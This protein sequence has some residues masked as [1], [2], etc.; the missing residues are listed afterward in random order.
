MD[1]K[2]LIS[3]VIDL[4]KNLDTMHDKKLL[5][6]TLSKM[7]RVMEL[8]GR[9]C[10]HLKYRKAVDNAESE[11]TKYARGQGA[12]AHDLS[13]IGTVISFLRSLG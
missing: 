4:F 9:R 12:G 1:K 10:D 7:R 5:L 2:I 6:T 13:R 11:L 3:S 8:I